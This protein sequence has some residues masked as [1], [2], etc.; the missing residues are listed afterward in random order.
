MEN[1]QQ[2]TSKQ[3]KTNVIIPLILVVGSVLVAYFMG[4]VGPAPEKY[5]IDPAIISKIDSLQ[6]VNDE[7]A[8]E[9]VRLD[10]MLEEYKLRVDDLDWKLGEIMR[11]KSESQDKHH[12]RAET[13]RSEGAEATQEFFKQRYNF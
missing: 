5:V 9:N 8:Q 12:Q 1:Q 13:A 11:R 4:G 2:E 7:L 10:S 3:K 6:Q